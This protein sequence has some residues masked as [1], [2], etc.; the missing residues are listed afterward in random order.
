MRQASAAVR[1]RF[2]AQGDGQF[3]RGGHS[4]K[5]HVSPIAITA[6]I[7]GDA[8]EPLSSL[9]S[10]PRAPSFALLTLSSAAILR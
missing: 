10:V 5:G 6:L 2:P 4:G 7:S 8:V 1:L 3:P 9:H